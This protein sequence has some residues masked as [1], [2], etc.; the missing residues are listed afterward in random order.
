MN[1][2]RFA[3]MMKYLTRA[4]KQKPD[5]P[6]VFPASKAPIPAKTQ[7]VKE[8]EAVN[9]FMLRNPR[10]EKNNGGSL[11]FYPK[12]SGGETT[13]QIAPGVDLKTRDINYGG[14]L[15]YEGDKFYGGVEYNTGKVK[16]DITDEGGTT[17]FK[18]TLSKDDAVNFI[19]GLGDRKGDKF[20]IR[21]DKDFT[22]MQVTFRKSFADGGMLVQPSADGSR[23]GYK[24]KT[25]DKA[26]EL[27]KAY[28]EEGANSPIKR[29]IKK[30][31]LKNPA[32]K[33]FIGDDRLK[34]VSEL[35]GAK[36]GYTEVNLIRNFITQRK[37]LNLL[38]NKGEGYITAMKLADILEIPENTFWN[39]L[40]SI[41]NDYPQYNLNKINSILSPEKITIKNNNF[42]YYKKPNKTQ[43][44]ELK[45][46]F[47]KPILNKNTVKALNEFANDE[48]I[49]K[50]LNDRKFPSIEDA[51]AVL[52]KAK[53][54]SSESNTAT[55]MLRLGEILQGKQ[56]KNTV[57]IKA[58]KVLGNYIVKQLENFDYY[59]PWSKGIYDSA[60]REITE[61]VPTQVGSI[62]KYK[63]L[64][65]NRL[66]KNFLEKKGLNINEVFSIKASA[67]NKAYPY[68]YFIDAIDKDINTRSL[69][70]FH[71]NLSK[72]Q[73]KL[74]ST[75]DELKKAGSPQ[76]RKI[77]YKKAEDIVAKFQKTREAHKNTILKNHG[78]KS[79]NLPNLVLGKEKQILNEDIKIAESVYKKSNLDNWA[80]QGI[81]ISGHA[82]KSGYVMTGADKPG[83]I[84]ATELDSS[85]KSQAEIL[86][87]M[88][89]K[90]KF[91]GSKGGAA[92]CDDPASY[93][94][95]INETR[96]NLNS[97]DVRVRAAAKAKLDKG[98]QVAKTLPTIGKFLRRAGQATLGG[99]SKALQA[100]GLGTPVGLA[101]E[102]I[103]EGGIYDY[104]RGKGYTH[105]Q[106]YQE[107]FFPG[108]ISGRPEGVPWYG[109]A[110][111]LLEK[112]LVGDPQQN[113]KVLQ[114]L[115]ALKDQDQVFDAFAR[116]EKFTQLEGTDQGTYK[117]LAS[118]ASADIQDLNRSGT[119]SNINRIMNPE[120]MAS[121]AYQTAVERQKGAQDQRARD[122]MAEN[123]V[124]QEPSE[125]MENQ[126]QKERNKDMLQMFPTPTVEDVQDVYKA[127][128]RGDD[129]KYF[130]AQ[131]YKDFMKEMDD[132]QKQSYF[133]D[134]FRLEKAGGGIAKLAGVSSGIAPESGPNP[135]GLLSL[136][137]RV[138]NY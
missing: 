48:S 63:T 7:N 117:K 44:K 80:S 13:Q 115:Q 121:Q 102:G 92:R 100:S 14:T 138:R 71:G 36:K 78:K 24:G 135:Q 124:Q 27:L 66:P 41:K 82:Q 11:K 130:Q 15:G 57:D 18:D 60:V 8:I 43:I 65:K 106:A 133:A 1:P 105:D 50:M 64:L 128:G 34:E 45:N 54:P 75:I 39:N 116:K 88:G 127:A 123:Y 96:K 84:L 19:V 52:K 2:A 87:T 77:A 73:N 10:V 119:I 129:L 4:K 55:A 61:N 76:E 110:E 20:Q 56:F 91:A 70:N 28:S 21:T 83:T 137:N 134:N 97:D 69:R 126:L 113:P 38:P 104:Y 23:P 47:D 112:E 33:K 51:Q 132:Y 122:Y 89:F 37:Q 26:D 32:F 81:D 42:I 101:V 93:T 118:D 125:F 114:Y 111:S 40:D 68:A 9:Q 3:Q 94:D 62:E 109:G 99:V 6:D 12:A 49:M 29:E 98:L 74:I 107:T 59:H 31:I 120:S 108:I 131:D 136:K 95:D 79:F 86:K 58:N 67:R 103:V 30:K 90:C 25:T 35:S 5:L 85:K 72:A 22:N 17:L 16:F 53:L 46:F